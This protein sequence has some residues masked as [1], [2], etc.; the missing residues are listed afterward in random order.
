MIII[1][2]TLLVALAIMCTAISTVI[3]S[4]RRKP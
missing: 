4:I 3:W 2:P 1:E